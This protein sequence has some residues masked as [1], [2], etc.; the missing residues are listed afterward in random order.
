MEPS[1]ISEYRTLYGELHTPSP[2]PHIKEIDERIVRITK[3][4]Q[5]TPTFSEGSNITADDIKKLSSDE[6]ADINR[7]ARQ[8]LWDESD[9]F[10]RAIISLLR[11][12]TF[13]W[14]TGVHQIPVKEFTASVTN[15]IEK[16]KA[17]TQFLAPIPVA[18]E[19]FLESV[20]DA[21]GAKCYYIW[22][23]SDANNRVVVSVVNEGLWAHYSTDFS[24]FARD[25]ITLT[26]MQNEYDKLTLFVK[27]LNLFEESIETNLNAPA[28]GRVHFEEVMGPFFVQLPLDNYP[29]M[30]GLL[31]SC[32]S[33]KKTIT[34]LSRDG[35][36]YLVSTCDT[37]GKITQERVNVNSY[38]AVTVTNETAETVRPFANVKGFKNSY[39]TTEKVPVLQARK[40]VKLGEKG[41]NLI[42]EQKEMIVEGAKQLGIF[43]TAPSV[44]ALK[45]EMKEQLLYLEPDQVGGFLY[46]TSDPQLVKVVH[47][48]SEGV[49]EHDLRIL[50]KGIDY[51]NRGYPLNTT[52]NNI[53]G[54]DEQPFV[55]MEDARYYRERV[56]KDGKPLPVI[57][58]KLE[59]NSALCRPEAKELIIKE[60]NKA[61]PDRAKL[62]GL[63]M[64]VPPKPE[65]RGWFD[66]IVGPSG[67][68]YKQFTL[69]VH[70]GNELE[71]LLID[72]DPTRGTM[73]YVYMAKHYASPEAILQ[74]QVRVASFTP[75]KQ[76]IPKP[77]PL[78]AP[79]PAPKP[80]PNPKLEP[81][82]SNPNAPG[83]IDTI[84]TIVSPAVKDSPPAK[85]PNVID[86]KIASFKAQL[87]NPITNY[88]YSLTA[89]AAIK[90]RQ[91]L[92]AQLHDWKVA[93]QG[94]TKAQARELLSALLLDESYQDN[95]AN[96]AA[97]TALRMQDL[98]Y[99]KGK[100]ARDELITWVWQQ[101]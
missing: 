55:S 97:I 37:D 40:F 88:Y 101:K 54:W 18:Q 20:S 13:G 64:I 52:L 28:F 85:K 48:T 44:E 98:P 45:L 27:D 12:V 14:Y 39:F 21:G 15:Y 10:N 66:Y 23:N 9:F 96:L 81:S 87:I 58:K 19:G 68:A 3:S 73:P 67:T 99:Q 61:T 71:S 41:Q 36:N 49:V 80:A 46:E 57:C 77:A 47:A 17:L 90:P 2:T 31:R 92:L 53:L 43:A 25:R 26:N 38:G 30:L 60:I 8:T 69:F 16:A 59:A 79:K 100:S 24:D 65:Y 32:A 1:F 83:L 86:N 95:Y 70:N 89:K 22:K 4:L 74:D 72:I 76:F 34:A 78:P 35:A 62:A 6:V 93:G 63:Y 94:L 33:L 42:R 91:A 50:D 84:L 7:L 75:Y 82:P 5:E 29:T 56:L 51:Q 11:I